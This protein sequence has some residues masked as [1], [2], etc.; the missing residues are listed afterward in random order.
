MEEYDASS[1]HEGL[2]SY[3]AFKNGK[4]NAVDAIIASKIRHRAQNEA[5][6]RQNSLADRIKYKAIERKVSDEKLKNLEDLVD[7]S[8]LSDDRISVDL[9]DDKTGKFPNTRSLTADF[10]NIGH[11]SLHVI[12]GTSPKLEV[13]MDGRTGSTGY[14]ENNVFFKKATGKSLNSV[15]NDKFDAEKRKL[16]L[17]E[18]FL[19]QKDIKINIDRFPR[20]NKVLYITGLSG[21]GKT[22][23]MVELADRY[24]LPGIE[25]D[26]FFSAAKREK[27]AFVKRLERYLSTAEPAE[28]ATLKYMRELPDSEY[29]YIDKGQSSKEQISQYIQRITARAKDYCE[30]MEGKNLP[31]I[32]EG[33]WLVGFGADFFRDRSLLVKGT[34]L[35]TSNIRA[36]KRYAEKDHP[37]GDTLHVI[38]GRLGGMFSGQYKDSDKALEAF[39]KGLKKE[40]MELNESEYA[41]AE[42]LDEDLHLIKKIKAKHAL[43]KDSNGEYSSY[44]DLYDSKYAEY[45]KS[46]KSHEEATDLADK[47]TEKYKALSKPIIPRY[48]KFRMSYDDYLKAIDASNE[49]PYKGK[50]I[51]VNATRHGK[52]VSIKF[53]H[54]GGKYDPETYKHT[55][56]E[57]GEGADYLA[58][59]H[60]NANK[61]GKKNLGKKDYPV[62]MTGKMNKDGTVT[63]KIGTLEESEFSDDLHSIYGNSPEIENI[64]DVLNDIKD[65]RYGFISKK[66]GSEILDRDWIHGCRNLGEYYSPET[67]PTKTIERKLGICQDQSLAT[68]Y[69]FKKYHPELQTQLYALIMPPFGHC[70]FCFMD[71]SK[72]YHLEN[73]WNKE[74]GLHGPF[75]SRQE[76]EDHLRAI[77]NKHHGLETD[78]RPEVIRFEEYQQR[79]KMLSESV[80]EDLRFI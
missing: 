72:W 66:D 28:A 3:L 13:D 23:T 47:D 43:K 49:D 10:E 54:G 51:I 15:V 25:L 46:G 76:L 39:K 22:T 44:S 41:K 6:N 31:C 59:C 52:P 74:R 14:G 32:I 8:K 53:K 65:I 61:A 16:G 9:H 20:K 18:S 64:K 11:M 60:G 33:S 30:Y 42:S 21:S 35:F 2:S 19:S 36:A 73:S 37:F 70:V 45:R 12:K 63:A 26:I 7:N 55:K 27:E 34:G 79:R 38:F 58:Q 75:T 57:D 71:D 29:G 50:S 80:S 68:E 62:S 48:K 1:L 24:D 17:L 69:L 78:A 4:K 56:D 77:Y 67:D 40:A 5:R